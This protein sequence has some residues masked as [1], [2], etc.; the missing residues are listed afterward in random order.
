MGAV[1][2]V[3]GTGAMTSMSSSS[4]STS[5]SSSSPELSSG[6]VTW[7]VTTLSAMPATTLP[8]V[9]WAAT[10]PTNLSKAIPASP[11]GL[12][13]RRAT[14]SSIVSAMRRYALDRPERARQ[15]LQP[16]GEEDES[17]QAKRQPRRL[18]DRP[19]DA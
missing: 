15:R 6:V 19:E 11:A 12:E 3:G 4:V 2:G 5:E 14:R 1:G 16:D 18:E 9:P 8:T 13:R 10:R 17:P 7:R